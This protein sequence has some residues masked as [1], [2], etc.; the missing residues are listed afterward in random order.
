MPSRDL[1]GHVLFAGARP[2]DINSFFLAGQ[3]DK[4]NRFGYVS[5][6]FLSRRCRPY[7]VSRAWSIRL[8]P[9]CYS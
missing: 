7:L 8:V 2:K 9:G 5:G 4:M 3:L 1:E 6:I